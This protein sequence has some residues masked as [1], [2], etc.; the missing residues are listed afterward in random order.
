MPVRQ[1]R[2]VGARRNRRPAASRV[3]AKYKNPPVAIAA[4]HT[5][6]TAAGHIQLAGRRGQSGLFYLR[7]R[8]GPVLAP[9]R[10]HVGVNRSRN[11]LH[12]LRADVGELHRQF[13]GD[14]LMHRTGNA[15][16]ADFREAFET[17]GNIHAVAKQV[18]VTLHDVADGN[19]DA[20]A[21]VPAGRIS[22]VPGPQAFLDIDRATHRFDRAGKFGENRVARGIENAPAGL[23]DKIVSD[24]SIG[25]QPPQ[26]FLFVLGNQPA[27]AGDIGGKNGCDFAFHEEPAPDDNWPENAANRAQAQPGLSGHLTAVIPG[28]A[29]LAQARNP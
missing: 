12:F 10:H 9:H 26:R 6:A 23:G 21:H 1:R 28:C 11:V 22:H 4:R 20:K 8:I 16:A 29:N 24:G 17:R 15:D 7:R 25:R 14:L 13:V 2:D 5:R 27:V 3:L 18:A 19:A